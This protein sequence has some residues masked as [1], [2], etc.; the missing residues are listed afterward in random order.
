MAGQPDF[1]K[2]AKVAGSGA[3]S[4]AYTTLCTTRTIADDVINPA[5][6]ASVLTG[7]SGKTFT[8]TAF[9]IVQP[10]WTPGAAASGA[11][12]I[13]GINFTQGAITNPAAPIAD[14][15]TVKHITAS[16]A[17]GQVRV[18]GAYTWMWAD[19]VMPAQAAN[20]ADNVAIGLKITGGATAGSASAYQTAIQITMAAA[21]DA[22]INIATGLLTFGTATGSSFQYGLDPAGGSGIIGTIVRSLRGVSGQPITIRGHRSAGSVIAFTTDN[23]AHDADVE[24]AVIGG[25]AAQGA[26][27][28]DIFEPISLKRYNQAVHTTADLAMRNAGWIGAINQAGNADVNMICVNT[29][30]QVATGAD[31]LL[32]GNLYTGAFG[33]LFTGTGNTAAGTITW[34]GADGAGGNLELS[35]PAA[36]AFKVDINA[37]AKYQFDATALKLNLPLIFNGSTSGAVTVTVA[38]AAGTWSMTLPTAVGTAGYFLVD[39]A[40][41]GITSWSNTLPAITLGGNITLGA[42]RNII[43]DY[44][45]QPNVDGEV[46]LGQTSNRFKLVRA[47]TVTAGDFMFENGYRLVESERIG[48]KV[49]IALVRPDGSVAK[50]FS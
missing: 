41:N 37:V 18:T 32:G 22:A 39:A 10:A 34:I 31:T 40:G 6:S 24:R 17:A 50:V 36:K 33:I 26:G 28:Y 48:K 49:G 4:A 5:P 9:Q 12:S 15:L 35:V 38:A 21:T 1:T 19:I 47:V 8:G 45:I 46:S 43:G 13:T 25:G 44:I 29:S 7:A 11:I 3:F 14:A 30:N 27:R 16:G 20:G 2:Q 42:N 23:A